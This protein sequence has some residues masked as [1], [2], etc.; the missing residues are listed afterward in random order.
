MCPEA[1]HLV[2]VDVKKLT[3][4]PNG[5][6]WRV[7]GRGADEHRASKRGTR[8]EPSRCMT[9]KSPLSMPT[10]PTCQQAG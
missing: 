3:R 2:H 10:M 6:G 1:R 4:I 7:L 8:V 9:M 5:G